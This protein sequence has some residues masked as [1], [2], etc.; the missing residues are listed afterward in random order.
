[1]VDLLKNRKKELELQLEYLDI[2]KYSKLLYLLNTEINNLLCFYKKKQVNQMINEIFSLSIS[3]S[4]FYAFC[5]K[6]SLYER[7][8]QFGYFCL[9]GQGWKTRRNC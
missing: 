1:M 8:I 2:I 5:S 3:V 7:K 9:Y 4:Y 6:K